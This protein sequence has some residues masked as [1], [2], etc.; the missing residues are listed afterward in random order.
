MTGCIHTDSQI[1]TG[2]IHIDSQILTVYSHRFTDCDR[3]YSQ[4]HAVG[5]LG[6]S[7]GGLKLIKWG[8]NA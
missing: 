3:V 7:C 1:V 8:P 4:T 5:D 2:C 6:N